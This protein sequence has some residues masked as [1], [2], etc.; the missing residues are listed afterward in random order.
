MLLCCAQ[1]SSCYGSLSTLLMP[2]C[3]VL[4]RLSPIK[5]IRLV[6]YKSMQFVSVRV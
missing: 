4:G 6:I 3:I 5:M 2:L 1:V